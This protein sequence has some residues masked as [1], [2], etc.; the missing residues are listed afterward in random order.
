M[1]CEIVMIM[2]LIAM[3]VLYTCIA[4]TVPSIKIQCDIKKHAYETTYCSK[5]LNHFKI[6]FLINLFDNM[7]I[8]IEKLIVSQILLQ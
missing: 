2:L 8:L 1:C 5:Y 7:L 3:I 6:S 4:N